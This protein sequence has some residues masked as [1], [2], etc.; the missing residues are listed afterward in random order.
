LE[1]F[2]YDGKT[3]A[4]I[5]IIEN[6]EYLKWCRKYSKCGG[7]ELKAVATN[8]NISLLK[9]GNYIWKNDYYEGEAGIIEFLEY[10]DNE[11]E[12][13]TVSGRFLTSLLSRRIV[14]RT[15]I[16]NGDISDCVAQILTNHILNPANPARKIDGMFFSH[17]NLGIKVNSQVSFRN[18]MDVICELCEN[19]EI[20]IKTAFINYSGAFNICLYR[21]NDTLCIFSKEYE[22]IIEQIFT[23]S[24]LDYSNVILIGGEGEGSSR[25]FANIGDEIGLE[26]R[27]IFTD[28]KDLRSDDFPDNY[29]EALLFR[30]QSKLAENAV[31]ESFSVTF[32]RYGNLQYKHDFDLGDKVKL[33]SKKLNLEAISRITEITEYYDK[34]GVS[35]D[36][37]FGKSMLTIKELLEKRG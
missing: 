27:E 29:I 7:F 28:A 24:V 16:L 30:G 32:N 14:W 3:R 31:I 37:T 10:F 33:V 20:G 8:D 2:V 12:F 21:G 35:L 6:C 13:I 36:L 34:D 25:Y 5:G 11:N 4:L 18:L 23:K 15:E 17:E 1:L 19:A 26:R 22:N 9:I